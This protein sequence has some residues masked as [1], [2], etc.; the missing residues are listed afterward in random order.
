VRVLS[1][2]F[3]VHVCAKGTMTGAS[4]TTVTC[5]NDELQCADGLKCYEARFQC[6]GFDDCEDYS[7]EAD[8]ASRQVE[9][10]P[11]EFYCETDNDC[12]PDLYLCDGYVDCPD[13]S[14][15]RDC[16]FSF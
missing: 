9:C 15:E 1:C 6:D 13:G 11:Y 10:D 2:N 8:C 16:E 4:N 3:D 7:D 5:S 12:L 14:D